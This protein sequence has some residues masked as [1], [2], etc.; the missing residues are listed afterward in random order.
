MIR[1]AEQRSYNWAKKP[2]AKGVIEVVLAIIIVAGNA[3]YWRNLSMTP[4]EEILR[5]SVKH[6]QIRRNSH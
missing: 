1:T 2:S 5:G 4:A 6:D 3:S